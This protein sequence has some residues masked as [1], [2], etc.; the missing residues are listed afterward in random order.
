M[1]LS[2]KSIASC[3]YSAGSSPHQLEPFQNKKKE[4]PKKKRKGGGDV[5]RQHQDSQWLVFCV[6]HL[7]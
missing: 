2:V 6:L 1:S 5:R 4:E 7:S 3:G